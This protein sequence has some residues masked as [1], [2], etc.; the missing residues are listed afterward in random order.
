MNFACVK[1]KSVDFYFDQRLLLFDLIY[2]H[3]EFLVRGKYT[4]Y[5][6]SI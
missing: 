4:A 2:F 6:M 5:A 3:I 1:I